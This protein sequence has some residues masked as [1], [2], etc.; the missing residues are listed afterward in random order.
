MD[1][2]LLST[3]PAC[4]ADLCLVPIGTGKTSIAAEVADVEHFLKTCGL[5]Y[6]I[7]SCGTTIEGSW[8]DMYDNAGPTSKRRWRVK[9]SKSRILHLNN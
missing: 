2:S 8:D 4:Y 3:P 9:L 6:T 5:K 1:Y 7:H